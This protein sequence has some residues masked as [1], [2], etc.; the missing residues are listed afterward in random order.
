MER[1]EDCIRGSKWSGW[2][3]FAPPFDSE[4]VEIRGDPIKRDRVTDLDIHV[5]LTRV[6]SLLRLGPLSGQTRP[7]RSRGHGHDCRIKAIC[8]L[9]A[10]LSVP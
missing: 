6:C 9:L 10:L 8:F 5:L 3:W 7:I 4:G 2:N 1:E